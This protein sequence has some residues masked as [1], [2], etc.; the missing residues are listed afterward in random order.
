MNEIKC[1][2]FIP[3]RLKNSRLPK[4]HFQ[5]IIG[6]P[7]LQHLVER[8]ALCKE[9]RNIVVC[10]TTDQTD[11]ELIDFLQKKKITFFRGNQNDILQRFLD[12]AKKFDTDII[13]DVAG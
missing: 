7:A 2:I 12:A 13:I 3:V 9:I 1:D 8:L 4:K 6:K 10:C 5:Q 11:D